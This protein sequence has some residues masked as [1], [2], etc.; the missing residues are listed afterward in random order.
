MM[1][2]LKTPQEERLLYA[3]RNMDERAKYES[4]NY[5]E[6]KAEKYPMRPPVRLRMVRGDKS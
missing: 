2:D 3:F 1:T 5:V 4:L 6:R